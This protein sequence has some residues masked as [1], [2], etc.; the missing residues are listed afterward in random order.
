MQRI[1]LIRK[2]ASIINDVD[3]STFQVGDV[4]RVPEATAAML[5]RE[6][7]AELVNGDKTLDTS[8]P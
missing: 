1:R 8:W 2:L 6:G 3:L 5:I 7:W 4:I